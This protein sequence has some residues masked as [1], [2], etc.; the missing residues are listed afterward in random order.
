MV[1]NNFLLLPMVTGAGDFLD[2]TLAMKSAFS[3]EEAE[4]GG[5][6]EAALAANGQANYNFSDGIGIVPDW[7]RLIIGGHN[8]STGGTWNGTI[9]RMSFYPPTYL[10]LHTTFNHIFHSLQK[11]FSVRN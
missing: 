10:T 2:T 7:N 3:W 4:D 6:G 5:S 11:E 9:L 8:G 1:L